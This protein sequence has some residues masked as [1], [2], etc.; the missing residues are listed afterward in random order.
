MGV[1]Y[2]DGNLTLHCGDALSVLR[3]MPDGSVQCVVTSPP[4]FSLR[5][6]G[7]DGQIG[8]E[9]TPTEY[10]NKLVEVFREVRRVLRG[11]GVCWINIADS[12]ASSSTPSERPYGNDDTIPQGCP[13]RDSILN[14]PCDECQAASILHT[15]HNVHLFEA[16]PTGDSPDPIQE[17]T[18][19]ATGH[20]PM[21]RSVHQTP[22][23]QS[24]D[25]TQDRRHKTGRVAELLPS[26]AVSMPPE[27]SAG[28]TVNVSTRHHGEKYRDES[29]F[30][31]HDAL[32]SDDMEAC[33]DG[34]EQ[35]VSGNHN[36]GKD[37]S[38]SACPYYTTT[39]RLF[40]GIKQ[41]DLI[42]IP[43]ALMIALRTD[44]WYVRSDVIWSKPNPMPESVTDRPTKAHEYIFLL[45]KS[46]KYYYDAEAVKEAVSPNSDFR[47]FD[48]KTEYGEK[49]GKAALLGNGSRGDPSGRNLRSVWWMATKPYAEAH[50]ATFPPELPERCIKAG[51]S[52]KGCCPKCGKGWVRVVEKNGGADASW[53]GSK[54]DDGK[55]LINHPTTGRR[56]DA[57]TSSQYPV[58]TTAKRLAL[59]RQQS[60]ENGGEYTAKVK[61]TGFSP[62]CACGLD[63]IPCAVLDPFAGSG[64]T[65]AVAESLGRKA[66]GIELNPEYIKL[67]KKRCHHTNLL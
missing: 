12:Y 44:G 21:S 6:Y 2:Q 37:V 58:G 59:L 42:G 33:S 8:L 3:T 51:T 38:F 22:M 13:L 55:N 53:H 7:V 23:H 31:V 18:V 49:C 17:H 25:A 26:S 41:K 9:K 47:K 29:D 34:N 60:R 20:A 43:Q 36:R 35:I 57:K 28:S 5:D 4:Y 62:A 64:T 67:I 50:F 10:I 46:A 27:S 65:L 14:R 54:F 45:T 52:E 39:S 16:K 32:P 1:A 11:D 56:E 24:S 63:P 15:F 66:I 19:S 30:D 40:Q 61:T 48:H